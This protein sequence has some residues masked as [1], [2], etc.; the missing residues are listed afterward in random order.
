MGLVS[1]F[2][3]LSFLAYLVVG[4]LTAA[5]Y[6]GLITLCV[7]V[8]SIDYRVSISIAYVVAVSFHFFANRNLT[9]RAVGSNV[10]HQGFRYVIVLVVNYLVILLAAYC[11]VDLLGM[12]SYLAAILSMLIPTCIGYFIFKFWVFS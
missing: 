9:F 5:I 4:G 3:Q 7:K 10:L 12:T 6:F 2:R 8:A 1:H 11:L